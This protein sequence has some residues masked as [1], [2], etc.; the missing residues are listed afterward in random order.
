MTN[1]PPLTGFK[2][3]VVIFLQKLILVL[4]RAWYFVALMAAV[5][6]LALAFLA[7]AFMAS[8]QPGA[9][10]T[11]Y[12]LL[13]PHNHQLPQRSYFVFGVTGGI[14][15]YSLAQLLAFGAEADNPE[16]FLGNADIG[17][18][19]GLNHRMVAIFS[20]LCLGGLIW[21]L[22]G[23]RPRLRLIPFLLMTLP[24]FIDGLSHMSSDGGAG[25]REENEWAVIITG[26]LFPASFYAGTIIGTL[27][28]LLR[29]ATGLLFG[30]GLAWFLFTYL[31]N[32]FAAIRRELEPKLRRAG[33]IK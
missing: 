9:G 12:A 16:A 5:T 29:T 32:R 20:G 19:T 33:A 24:L 4:A 30:L 22:A 8:D 2:R 15:T 26:G 10:R 28:W 14:Q 23:G 18:K 6:F 1:Q 27:D 25:F 13:A 7:P 17:Y 31:S 21:G 3:D 11:I